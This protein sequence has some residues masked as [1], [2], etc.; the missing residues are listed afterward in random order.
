[1]NAALVVEGGGMRGVYTAGVLDLFLDKKLYF[2]DVYGVSAGACNAASYLSRQRERAFRASTDYLDDKRYCSLYSLLKT[3]D[4][5]DTELCYDLI[6]NKF[7]PYD[8]TEYDKFHGNFVAVATNCRTGRAEYLP[9]KDMNYGIKAIQASASLPLVS[10]NVEINGEYYLDGG[11]ADAIPI[12]QAIRNGNSK[13]VLLLTRCKGYRKSPNNFSKL[14]KIKYRKFPEI[15]EAMKVRHN[16][17]NE[18][19]EFIEREEA[20]GNIFV[21]R[22]L[23]EPQIKRIEKDKEE[24]R[25]LYKAGYED[26]ESILD[27][28]ID[29]L[30]M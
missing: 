9:V 23:A 20:A 19:L 2:D 4:L 5:F 3:G 17:Y 8:Y 6:P 16:V 22:P 29:Y 24:M 21:I 7:D 27:K 12:K 10:R 18:T 30:N 28:L 15:A 13:N 26:A 14:F 11:I 25:E 1:M